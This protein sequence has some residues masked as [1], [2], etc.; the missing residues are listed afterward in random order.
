MNNMV[1]QAG[2]DSLWMYIYMYHF[3]WSYWFTG[4]DCFIL[5]LFYSSFLGNGVPETVASHFQCCNT[6]HS[7][8]R[9]PYRRLYTA[10]HCS[11]RSKCNHRWSTVYTH[12]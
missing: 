9:F 1:Q 7:H 4:K 5:C 10:G 3:V 8:D 11:T 12:T 2:T 6:S